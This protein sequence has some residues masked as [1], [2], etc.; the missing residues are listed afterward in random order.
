MIYFLANAI[1]AI[2]STRCDTTTNRKNNQTAA[3]P[4]RYTQQCSH[5]SKCAAVHMYVVCN[6]PHDYVAESPQTCGYGDDVTKQTNT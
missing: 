3:D 6:L 2:A 4:H 5:V 1:V